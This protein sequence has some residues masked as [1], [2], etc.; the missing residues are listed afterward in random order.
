MSNIKYQPM[1]DLS[2]LTANNQDSDIKV[3]EKDKA[4]GQG[5]KCVGFAKFVFIMAAI[6]LLISGFYT[7]I[8]AYAAQYLLSQAWQ[9][10]SAQ[11]IEKPWPWLDSFPAAKLYFPSLDDDHIVLAGDSGQ[12]LAFGPGL[13]AM[14]SE[15][16]S[17]GTIVIAGHRDTH[18]NKLQY[19][20]PSEPL[21]L[22][23]MDGEQHHYI[24]NNISVIDVNEQQIFQT[25]HERLLLI[26]CYP[27]NEDSSTSLR[28]VIE[29]LPV[30]KSVDLLLQNT[31]IAE[32]TSSRFGAGIKVHF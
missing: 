14:S 23:G 32:K 30:V 29:A 1:R 3:N 4:T 17:N 22:E 9:H 11:H 24:I 28:Y 21:T 26:T 31:L 19:L 6:L 16:G 27:F 12:A 10:S 13:N 7:H 2:V 8:K 15:P 25:A 20:N 18:F 5:K